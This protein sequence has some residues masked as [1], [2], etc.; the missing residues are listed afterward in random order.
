[1]EPEDLIRK[2]EIAM[3][4]A[5]QGGRNRCEYYTQEM[6]AAVVRR[7]AL[8][9]RLRS[10]LKEESLA[11]HFQPRFDLRR[12][13]IVGAEALLRWPHPELGLIPPAQFLPLAEE[14]DLIVPIGEWVLRTACAQTRVWHEAGLPELRIAV[15]VSSHQVHKGGLREAVERALRDARLDASLLEIEITESALIGDAPEVVETLSG[16]RRLGVRIALDDFGTGYSSLSSLKRF[17][18]DE[19]KVDRS[20]VSGVPGD[21]DG[22]AI[23]T[24]II[25]M[26]HGLG[27]SVVAEGVETDA[28][29][30]FL[31][32]RGCD[33]FQG[34]FFSKPIPVSDWME[35]VTSYSGS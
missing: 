27:L 23:V 30:A 17:P 2:A 31:K 8:E 20:F 14:T 1:M 18:I 19:L 9:A 29:L 32:D 25:A 22:E 12:A 5:K 11:L 33:E 13:R 10:A 16:L 3:H 6:N 24:A 28:Q 34:Y 15:N 26:A 21:A 4:Y 7:A 35:F